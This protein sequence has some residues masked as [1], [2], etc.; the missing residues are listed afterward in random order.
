M[1]QQSESAARKAARFADRAFVTIPE[2][3]LG[4]LMLTGV[5][6]TFAN[7]VGRYVFDVAIYWAEEIL[8]FIVIWGVFV[9]LVVAT[10]R[11][12]FLA[13]DLFTANLAGWPKRTLNAAI[14]ITLV[15]CCVYVAL[16]SWKVVM[17]FIAT[18]QRTV[19]AGIPKAIPHSAL[20]VGLSLAAVAM[21][22]RFRAF[23][24]GKL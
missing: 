12:G 2:W 21:L 20:L 16:Q 15:L 24:S 17:L 11:G 22:L 19:S 10:Y 4:S 5:G 23:V 8:V 3:I 13:M 1:G 6:I 7:V 18:D 14:A 9:G